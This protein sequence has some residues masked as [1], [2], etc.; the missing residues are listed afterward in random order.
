MDFNLCKEEDFPIQNTDNFRDIGHLNHQGAQ[1]FTK[2]FW[3]TIDKKDKSSFCKSYKEKL[4]SSKRKVYG[5]I[6]L[7]D[8]KKRKYEIATNRESEMEYQVKFSPESNI[9]AIIIKDYS[10]EKVFEMESNDHGIFEI[11][12]KLPECQDV[13]QVLKIEY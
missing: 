10:K 12:V 2:Y 4:N 3:K 13:F 9:P 8:G 1:M 6:Y 7:D 5:L 11:T